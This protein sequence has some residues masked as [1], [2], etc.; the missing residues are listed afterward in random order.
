MKKKSG[1]IGAICFM[2]ALCLLLF[3]VERGAEGTSIQTIGDALWYM[4]VTLTTVGYGDLYPVTPLGK[5]IGT[6]FILSSMG[7][8]AFIFSAVVRIVNS[9]LR[10]AVYLKKH[11]DDVWYVFSE[12]N[13]KT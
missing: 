5:M 12:L 4:V 11:R 8:L 7:L 3:V 2:I 9:D 13:E 6:L 10:P 1:F